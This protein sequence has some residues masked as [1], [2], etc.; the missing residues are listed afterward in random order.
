MGRIKQQRRVSE[1]KPP[2]A[3]CEELRSYLT[4]F[5]R[6]T[7]LPVRYSQLLHWDEAMPLYDKNGDD[8][9]WLTVVYSPEKMK[10]FSAGLKKIYAMLKTDGDMSFIDHLYVDRIDSCT[11]GNSNP[12]RIRIVNSH[13]ENQDYYYIKKTD[14]SRIFGLELEHLL[15]PN[16]IHY[17]TF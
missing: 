9:L 6:D 5:N 17:F 15:S 8:T 2:C 12:F 16:R 1:K 7:E 11:F 4:R 10:Q 3:V 14:A 13:N